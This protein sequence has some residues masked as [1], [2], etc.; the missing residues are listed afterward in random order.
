MAADRLCSRLKQKREGL[1]GAEHI[2][3]L[4]SGR[5]QEDQ[6]VTMVVAK[7]LQKSIPYVSLARGGFLG[8]C[9]WWVW[10]LSMG[11]CQTCWWMEASWVIGVAGGCGHSLWSDVRLLRWVWQVVRQR[12]RWV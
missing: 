6:Y 4:G 1:E 5:E 11:G 9:G 3:F 2:C 12:L 10:P 7:F 8:G